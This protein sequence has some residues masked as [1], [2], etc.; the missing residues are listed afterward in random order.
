MWICGIIPPELSKEIISICKDKNKNIG[1]K[2]NVFDLPLHISMKKSFY[3]N[4]FDDVKKRITN[5]IYE[6]GK[7]V[8]K[9]KGIYIHKGMIWILVDSKPFINEWHDELDHILLNDFNIDISNYDKSFLP[10][11]SLFT[12]GENDKINSMYRELKNDFKGLDF[13]INKFV[14]GSSKHKD[15]YIEIQ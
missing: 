13:S 12:S 2:E 11:I 3:T 1:L 7:I 9:T 14:I 15:E 6:K 8:C 10:H 4:N 5:F